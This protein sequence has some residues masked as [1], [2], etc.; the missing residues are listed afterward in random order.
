MATASQSQKVP[1]YV[2]LCA[3]ERQDCRELSF[4][5]PENLTQSIVENMGAS[6]VVA[7]WPTTELVIVSEK[8][9]N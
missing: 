9:R 2:R 1:V 4:R 6:V 8:L 7:N 5:I 3:D